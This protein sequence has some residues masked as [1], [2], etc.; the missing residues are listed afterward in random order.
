MCLV[1]LRRLLSNDWE[2]LWKKW[3]PEDKTNFSSG[4]FVACQ[5]EADETL[6]K[7]Y[8]DLIGEMT[9]NCLGERN[10][11]KFHLCFILFNGRFQF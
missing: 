8:C 1:L 7:R 4:L 2:E 11:N 3:S 5:N 6:R 10:K 9:R